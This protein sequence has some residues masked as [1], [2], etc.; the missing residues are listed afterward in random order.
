MFRRVAILIAIVV[1][2]LPL[3]GHAAD[4]GGAIE[5]PLSQKPVETR[6]Y[7]SIV[8][9]SVAWCPHCSEAKEYMT[10]HNIPFINRDV[11]LD[12][13]AMELLTGKYKSQ[14]VPLIVIGNDEKILHGFNRETFEKV[15]KEVELK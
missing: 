3:A 7:P 9:Y 6:K 13:K 10:E 4:K 15:L 14:A 12:P 1:L 2:L 5:T 11:E 8:L